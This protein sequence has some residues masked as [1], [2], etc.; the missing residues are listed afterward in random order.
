[1]F[2]MQAARLQKNIILKVLIDFHSGYGDT[3]DVITVVLNTCPCANF[4]FKS[5]ME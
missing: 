3:N 4:N 5:H 2:Q 1:M